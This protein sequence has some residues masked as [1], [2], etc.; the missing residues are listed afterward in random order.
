[1]NSSLRSSRLV[2]DQVLGLQAILKRQ[3]YDKKHV[4]TMWSFECAS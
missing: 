3:I 1:M 2:L 4:A